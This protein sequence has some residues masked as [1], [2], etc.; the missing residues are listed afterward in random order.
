[1]PPDPQSQIKAH[2]IHHGK[3]L[4]C[5]PIVNCHFEH[6]ADSLVKFDDDFVSIHSGMSERCL[7]KAHIVMR[8][9]Q[10]VDSKN[11]RKAAE[12][13]FDVMRLPRLLPTTRT[14]R[15]DA[16]LDGPETTVRLVRLENEALQ[17]DEILLKQDRNRSVENA[18]KRIGGNKEVLF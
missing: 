4:H 17:Q 13:L 1:M 7:A 6:H 3:G 8:T 5:T 15:Q 14:P 12:K 10:E 2:E 16:H 9:I 11:D 18:N